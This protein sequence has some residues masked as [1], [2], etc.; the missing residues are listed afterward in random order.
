[1]CIALQ[2]AMASSRETSLAIVMSAT[3]RQNRKLKTRSES[4][5]AVG[6]AATGSCR[7]IVVLGAPG[8][9][10]VSRPATTAAAAAAAAAACI[11][12]R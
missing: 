2:M 1:M 3:S 6:T 7:S 10:A 12:D 11:D 8:E 4:G 5:A 9:T